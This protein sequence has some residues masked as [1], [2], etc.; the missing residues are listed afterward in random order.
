VP[1]LRAQTVALILEHTDA[2][3][4]H[5]SNID[6]RLLSRFEASWER[7]RARRDVLPP[8]WL[9][10]EL[11]PADRL[12]DVFDDVLERARERVRAQRAE[13]EELARGDGL[14]PAV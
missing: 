13:L 4:R 3:I 8:A 11:R 7:E 2:D 10:S 6:E 14:D 12:G 1:V 9:E 5:M